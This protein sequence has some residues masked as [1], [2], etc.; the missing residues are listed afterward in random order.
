MIIAGIIA[1]APD[2]DVWI[3]DLFVESDAP[4]W[5]FKVIFH[6]NTHCMSASLK[7]IPKNGNRFS[8]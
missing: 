4:E 1:V 2:D 8:E 6:E 3:C 5:A 7:R